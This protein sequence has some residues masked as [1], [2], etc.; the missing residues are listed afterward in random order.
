MKI[1]FSI[2]IF[3]AESWM[4][5]EGTDGWGKVWILSNSDVPVAKRRQQRGGSVMI[6]I[7]I[8]NQSWW[9]S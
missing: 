8:V 7:G 9:K 2:V 4:T 3:T 5:F 1:D 6:W